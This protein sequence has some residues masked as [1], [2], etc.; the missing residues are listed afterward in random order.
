M[1]RK[2][3]RTVIEIATCRREEV[4]DG[5]GDPVAGTRLFALC[6]DGTIWY[7]DMVKNAADEWNWWIMPTVPQGETEDIVDPSDRNPT[8]YERTSPL[9]R[10]ELIPGPPAL[11]P[12][13]S[14]RGRDPG[15]RAWHSHP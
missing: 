13:P 14:N 11:R 7:T 1:M 10:A 2:M 8:T 4:E 6:D 5:Y 12:L 3:S 15:E 9:S